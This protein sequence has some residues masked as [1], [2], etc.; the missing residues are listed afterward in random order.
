MPQLPTTTVVTPWLIFGSMCG[1]DEDDLVVVGVD[2]DESRRDDPAA[3]VEHVGALARQIRADRD[4][5][6]A[7]DAHVGGEARRAACRR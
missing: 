4:D 7:L 3:G 1:A 2:V 5:A 6:L